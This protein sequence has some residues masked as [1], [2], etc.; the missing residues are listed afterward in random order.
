MSQ[1]LLRQAETIAKNWNAK[2]MF[3]IPSDRP[4]AQKQTRYS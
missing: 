1:W 3:L 4:N 2:K